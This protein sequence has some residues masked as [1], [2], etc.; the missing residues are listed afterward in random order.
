MIKKILLFIFLF[1]FVGFSLFQISKSRTFQ[2]FGG[3]IGRV[4]TEEK[5][6]ALTFDDAPSEYTNEVLKI[7][8]EK[9]VKA[10]FYTIG[11]NLEKYPDVAKAIA[12]DG[13]ELGNHS[14]SHTRMIFKSQK[15]IGS[16]I[17][18]TNRLI[19]DSGYAGEITFRPPNGKKLF[20]LPWYLRENNIKAITWDVEPDTYFS[21]HADQITDYALA[22]TKP[23]SIILLHPFC[24]EAC[25]ADRE[26]LPQIIDGLKLRGYNFLTV[27]ELL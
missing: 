23:G 11:Q 15:F 6:V 27:S 1:C 3:L 10:T 13:H 5:I 12:R 2:F 9:N 4:E 16:E 25:V 7:L 18:K 17:E 8:E 14:Y 22:N 26:A 24:G 20:G 19:R 21:G